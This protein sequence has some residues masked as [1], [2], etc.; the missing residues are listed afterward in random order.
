MLDGMFQ[1]AHI[2]MN[3]SGVD[4]AFEIESLNLRCTHLSGKECSEPIMITAVETENINMAK[5][6]MNKNERLASKYLE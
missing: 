6:F 2:H 3:G 4:V 1:R 5:N